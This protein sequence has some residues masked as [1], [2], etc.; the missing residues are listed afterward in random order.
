MALDWTGSAEFTAQ[1][2]RNWIVES[3]VAGFTRSANG[4]TFAT[5]DAAGHMVPY[6]K[7]KEALAMLSRWL[8]GK[9]L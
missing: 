5:V 3:Q 1:K 9:D 2:D 6:D 4:L 7:P 8:E